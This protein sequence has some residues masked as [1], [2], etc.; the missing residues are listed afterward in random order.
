MIFQLLSDISAALC[1]PLKET[2]KQ[3]VQQKNL[4][5]VFK[6]SCTVSHVYICYINAVDNISLFLGPSGQIKADSRQSESL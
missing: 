4:L 3:F 6:A 1:R 2:D 5:F